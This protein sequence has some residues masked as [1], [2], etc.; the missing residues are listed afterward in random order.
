MSK[1][2]QCD[3]RPLLNV[4]LSFNT[5]AIGLRISQTYTCGSFQLPFC[6]TSVWS[7]VQPIPARVQGT[8]RMIW[9]ARG[10]NLSGLQAGD[11][12]SPEISHIVDGV[13]ADA[14]D[15]IGSEGSR[16]GATRD[17]A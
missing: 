13:V 5:G 9:N 6:Q 12:H 14:V 7:G 4:N 1:V 11:L 15:C 2:S 8:G 3:P 10:N 16:I 17:T